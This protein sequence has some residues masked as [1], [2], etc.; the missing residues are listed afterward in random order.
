MDLED[1]AI[2]R[3]LF[4]HFYR[5]RPI[6]PKYVT[7]WPVSQ[8][9]NFLETWHP[10]ESLSLKQITLKVA[11]L[12]AISSSDRGQTLH[13]ANI[14]DLILESDNLKFVIKNLI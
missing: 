14:D 1:N 7:F 11:A 8:L 10:P 3:R 5:K 4:K 12:L 2:V 13:L 9:L 6:R